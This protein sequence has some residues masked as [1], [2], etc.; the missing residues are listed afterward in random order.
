MNKS[1]C[2]REIINKKPPVLQSSNSNDNSNCKIRQPVAPET[3]NKK[4][5]APDYKSISLTLAGKLLLR[6]VKSFPYPF[7]TT[8][9]LITYKLFP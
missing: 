5:D 2:G 8:E 3:K 7:S 6:P 9:Y 1:I 4:N